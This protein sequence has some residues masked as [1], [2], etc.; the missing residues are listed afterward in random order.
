MTASVTYEKTAKGVAVLQS[1]RG[2]LPALARRLLILMDGKRNVDELTTLL[3]AEGVEPFLATL[4]AEGYIYRELAG[5][6]ARQSETHPQVQELANAPSAEIRPVRTGS[7]AGRAMWLVVPLGAAMA[8]AWWTMHAQS[9][10]TIAGQ[11]LADAAKT[12]AVQDAGANAAPAAESAGPA[13][14][15]ARP[16]PTGGASDLRSTGEVRNARSSVDAPSRSQGAAGSPLIATGKEPKGDST[17]SG[18]VNAIDQLSTHDVVAPPV[19]PPGSGDSAAPAETQIQNRKTQAQATALLPAQS[20]TQAQ[21]AGL[22]GQRSNDSGDHPALPGASATDATSSPHAAPQTSMPVSAPGGAEIPKLHIINK[23][24]PKLP[25][26]AA[27]AGIDTGRF[28]VRLQV[29]AQGI[30]EHVEL[31]RA[32]PPEIYDH[33]VERTLMRWTFDPPGHTVQEVVSVRFE[34]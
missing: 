15:A 3:G 1:T 4:L 28:T 9:V 10:S 12:V 19:R 6:D 26:N 20:Q 27:M 21:P 17:R 14:V 11:E 2:P 32:E 5:P 24:I 18:T 7:L 13:R 23:V 16:P 34:R 31:L 22:I 25:T 33:S 30:V 29:N 8:Y